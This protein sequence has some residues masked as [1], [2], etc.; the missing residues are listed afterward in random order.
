MDIC[1]GNE[2]VFNASFVDF[3]LPNITDGTAEDHACLM[4][5]IVDPKGD[6]IAENFDQS[7]TIACNKHVYSPNVP[8]AHSLVEQLDLPSCTEAGNWPLKVNLL[9]IDFLFRSRKYLEAS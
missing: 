8:Y 9:H 3:A 6:C 4:F 7:E 5:N 1:D 2:T